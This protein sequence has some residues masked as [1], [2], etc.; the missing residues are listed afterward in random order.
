[1]SIITE[2]TIPIGMFRRGFLLS[3]AIG[4]TAS[5]PL[6]A[7]I[8]NTIPRNRFGERWKFP[9]LIGSKLNPP[10]P[11]LTNDV[12]ASADIRTISTTPVM[13][14]RRS[15]TLMPAYDH[16]ATRMRPAI[17]QICH[18]M[19]TP[20]SD[21][22]AGW[23]TSCPSKESVS[24]PTG[25]SQI[26]KSHPAKNPARGWSARAIHVY[27][28]PADGKTLASWAADSAWMAS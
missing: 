6:N 20:Y 19:L 22:R 10:G 21:L 11:G 5:Q 7:K 16:H 26:E 9:G 18:G 8:E 12:T 24:A 17:G 28:P 1:M 27:H 23:S 13:I 4:A 15:E 14:M 3:S 2:P 25:G